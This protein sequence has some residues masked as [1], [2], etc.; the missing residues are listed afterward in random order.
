MGLKVKQI[1]K[2]MVISLGNVLHMRPWKSGLL[3]SKEVKIL[4]GVDYRWGKPLSVS[5]R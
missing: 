4:I 5:T 3:V 2:D 1:L